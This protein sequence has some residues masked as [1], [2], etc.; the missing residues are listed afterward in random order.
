MSQDS[1]ISG[2]KGERWAMRTFG[3]IKLPE[4]SALDLYDP[5]EDVA[6]EVKLI[7]GQ[8][9]RSRNFGMY[10]STLRRIRE[11]H[12]DVLFIYWPAGED[13]PRSWRRLTFEEYLVLHE[14][15]NPRIQYQ[16]TLPSR[17]WEEKG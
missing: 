2:T 13:E 17:F 5:K 7:G 14:S 1:T 11:R 9:G 12:A 8:G 3:L 4:K 10:D 15:V 6:V 16:C